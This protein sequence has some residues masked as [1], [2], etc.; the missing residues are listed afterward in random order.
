MAIHGTVEPLAENVA[1][2]DILALEAVRVFLPDV[3]RGLHAVVGALTTTAGEAL[4]GRERDREFKSQID[5]LI[6]S[7]GAHG[8][9]VEHMIERLFPAAHRHIANN[10]Y[11]QEWQS[12]WLKE[13]RVAHQ[14]I[15]RFYLERV[16]GESLRAFTEAEEAWARL[17][18][19]DALAQYLR[20]LDPVI[21]RMSFRRWKSM[22]I[23]SPCNM[24]SQVSLCFSI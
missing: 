3:F 8:S 7:A 24:L 16:V 5:E 1:L 20:S 4:G 19:A 11:G 10:H 13:R 9:V 23:S 21:C 2:C 18:D 14:A 12:R 22:R 15:L 17:T 6:R